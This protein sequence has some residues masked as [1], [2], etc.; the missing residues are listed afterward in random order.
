[1]AGYLNNIALNLEIVLKNKADSSEVSET[2]VT[3]ICENLLL[4]KEV[5]FLKADGSVENFKLS[6]MAYEITN[7]EELPE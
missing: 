3:R 1:M 4:S 7:T 2:L 5:S 6:D